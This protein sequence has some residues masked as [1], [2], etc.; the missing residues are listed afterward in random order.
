MGAD[1]P[2]FSTQFLLLSNTVLLRLME[3]SVRD[4]MVALG[5]HLSFKAK[6]EVGVDLEVGD[7]IDPVAGQSRYCLVGTVLIRKW[8]NMEAT[9]NTLASIWRLVKGMHIRVLGKNLYFLFFSPC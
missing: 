5:E 3:S 2:H 8:Y 9:K 6:E 4:L 7:V 1:K